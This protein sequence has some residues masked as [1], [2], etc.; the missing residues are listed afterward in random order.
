MELLDHCVELVVLNRSIAGPI[1]VT[2]KTISD[3]KRYN[4]VDFRFQPS[5]LYAYILGENILSHKL[6]ASE[7]KA[8]PGSV[9][10]SG[11]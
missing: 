6:R 1:V 5:S 11:K 4:G 8:D 2:T 7:D 9:K 10:E 3:S